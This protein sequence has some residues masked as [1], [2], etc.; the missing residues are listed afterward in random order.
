MVSKE[1][2]EG[3]H[4][5]YRYPYVTKVPLHDSQGDGAAVKGEV[6]EFD[7]VVNAELL[8][9]LD[10]LE[11]HP[12]HYLRQSIT[13]HLTDSSAELDCDSYILENAAT[14]ETIKSHLLAGSSSFLTVPS[15]DWRDFTANF[16]S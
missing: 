7:E 3:I 9:K 10:T 6:Y 8:N 1:I 11:G 13:V 2:R 14:L 16:A 12:G 5:S 4:S 15:G